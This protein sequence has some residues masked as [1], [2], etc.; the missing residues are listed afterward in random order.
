MGNSLFILFILI[1]V[2]TIIR[3]T[4]FANM[5]EQKKRGRPIGTNNKVKITFQ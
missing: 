2:P 5:K 4:I 3:F 1:N